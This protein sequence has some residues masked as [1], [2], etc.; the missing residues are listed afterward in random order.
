MNNKQSPLGLHR[1]KGL[2]LSCKS[3]CSNPFIYNQKQAVSPLLSSLDP[4]Y[5]LIASSAIPVGEIFPCK[6]TVSVRSPS[7]ACA[8]GFRMLATAFRKSEIWVFRKI[9]LLFTCLVHPFPLPLLHVKSI[10][11]RKPKE[12]QSKGN[13]V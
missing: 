5:S 3:T 4:V 13:K 1:F 10:P 8:N 6:G 11:T 7:T 9:R 2:C 12:L